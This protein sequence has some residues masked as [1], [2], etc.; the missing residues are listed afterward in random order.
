M[1]DKLTDEE[2]IA[3]AMLM[4]MRYHH[5]NGEPFYYKMAEDG[6]P[7]IESMIEADT[8]EPIAP[9]APEFNKGGIIEAMPSMRTFARTKLAIHDT[10]VRRSASLGRNVDSEL[11]EDLA[12]A[13]AT[14]KREKHG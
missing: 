11:L 10:L 3:R 2:H 7:S 9:L 5:G 8:L 12:G 6:T 4:G 1:T 13:I 14:S